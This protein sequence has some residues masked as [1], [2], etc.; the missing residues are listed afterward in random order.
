MQYTL[1]VI[2][3]PRFGIISKI[4]CNPYLWET[5]FDAFWQYN[6]SKQKHGYNSRIRRFYS[7]L[8]SVLWYIHSWSCYKWALITCRC[9]YNKQSQTSS[10]ANKTSIFSI[11]F[12]NKVQIVCSILY[13]RILLWPPHIV[14]TPHRYITR[15]TISPRQS[16]QTH[17]GKQT[18]KSH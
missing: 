1:R 16:S 4:Y 14:H 7:K 12:M 8:Y 3:S 6:Y 15:H 9:L 2:P 5:S 18:S 17:P 10:G 11:R 13:L